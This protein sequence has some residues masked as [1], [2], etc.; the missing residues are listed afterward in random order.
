MYCLQICVI[1]SYNTFIL[2]K[3]QCKSIK[4]IRHFTYLLFK[5]IEIK[6][7]LP[8][9]EKNEEEELSIQ[10]VANHEQIHIIDNDFI[11]NKRRHQLC[12]ICV[13]T[14]TELCCTCG[15]VICRRCF[16]LHLRKLKLE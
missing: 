13:K 10:S 2:R 11:K 5:A 16:V 1:N 15:M 3:H 6:T 4:S 12:R 7:M 14:E 9:E 8:E